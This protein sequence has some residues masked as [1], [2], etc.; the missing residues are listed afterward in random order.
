MNGQEMLRSL[1]EDIDEK[2]RKFLELIR[3]LHAHQP[4]EKDSR[5]RVESA[6]VDWLIAINHLKVS[7]PFLG[8]DKL[9]HSLLDSENR[10]NKI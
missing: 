8:A 4:L 9:V 6:R 10:A 7:L 1:Q 5:D 2:K 3:D